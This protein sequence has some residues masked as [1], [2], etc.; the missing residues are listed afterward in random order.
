MYVPNKQGLVVA[1]H[2]P[3]KAN[4]IRKMLSPWGWE[5]W[6]LPDVGWNQVIDEDG[7]TLAENAWLKAETVFGKLGLPVLADDTGLFVDALGGAPG[8]RTARYAGEKVSDI[9]NI[10]KLLMSLRDAPTR[11][12]CFVT[13]IVYVSES[14]IWF[15]KGRLCGHIAEA[16]RG[17]RG[18]GYDPI[19]IPEGME[20]TLAELSLEEKNRIS[21][22]QQAL[23]RWV[24]FMRRK[25]F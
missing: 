6:T 8:V 16:P 12:A 25:L 14:G 17:D 20:R 4:E 24:R 21:H 3:H 15:G 5:I 13:V 19:F 2:N 10:A 7:E 9:D 22:R 11:R 1:T 18:F 23:A